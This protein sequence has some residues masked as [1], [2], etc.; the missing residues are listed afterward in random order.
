MEVIPREV[1]IKRPNTWSREIREL[2]KRLKLNSLQKEVLVGSL[3]GDGHLAPNAYGKNYRFQVVHMKE[4]KSYVDYKYEIFKD[5]CISEPQFQEINNSW[6]FRT[7]S[8][9]ILTEFHRLFYR[10][11]RKILPNDLN[12]I[13]DSPI[14]LAI[15]FMDD[16]SVGP[17]R[18]GLTLNTQN[19]TK[20]E[21]ERLINHFANKFHYRVSLHRDKKSWR[22]YIFPESSL[23]FKKR[24]K[25][26]ILPEFKYKLCYL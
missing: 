8:H 23:E 15:W 20:E 14:T 12:K 16:G 4:H 26:F 17:R 18:R 1:E 25:K 13:L 9:P 21:N 11:A 7:I 2:Q 5:W 6:R 22:L 19:F 10:G 24:I 3:L